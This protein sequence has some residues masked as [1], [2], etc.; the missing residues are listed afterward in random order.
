[1]QKFKKSWHVLKWKN[2][3]KLRKVSLLFQPKK[4]KY[5]I[6]ATSRSAEISELDGKLVYAHASIE[7]LKK[8]HESEKNTLTENVIRDFRQSKQ[9]YNLKAKYGVGFLKFGFHKAR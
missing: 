1:M 7:A 6:Q 5:F 2:T 3:R 8:D 4:T 9:C